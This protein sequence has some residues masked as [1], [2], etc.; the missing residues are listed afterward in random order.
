[1]KETICKILG[2]STTSYY[3]WRKERPIILL[4]ETYF[5][6]KDLLQFIED[7]KIDKLEIKNSENS[8]LTEFYTNNGL[9]KLIIKST[10]PIDETDQ[11]I[12]KFFKAILNKNKRYSVIPLK[13]FL[14]ILN[15]AEVTNK[16]TLIDQIEKSNIKENWKKIMIKFCNYELSQLE[17]NALIE[18][19]IKVTKY[20][21]NEKTD[22]NCM[23]NFS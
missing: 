12:I 21:E 13:S 17:I 11:M 20:F 2:I 5:T 23:L 10:L 1:M 15:L 16:Q 8:N 18:N 4:L 19:K 6:K 3:R 14:A 22:K 7:G 9:H